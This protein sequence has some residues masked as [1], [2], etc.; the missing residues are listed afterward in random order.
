MLVSERA[1]IAPRWLC[2]SRVRGEAQERLRS[3]TAKEYDTTVYADSKAENFVQKLLAEERRRRRNYVKRGNGRFMP[4]PE[5]FVQK[6]L[7]EE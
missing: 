4:K 7:A 3:C 5:N 6:L 2:D 1:Q